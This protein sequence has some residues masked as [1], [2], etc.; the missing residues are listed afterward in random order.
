MFP[1]HQPARS[2]SRSSPRRENTNGRGGASGN[3][4]G[5]VMVET[6]MQLFHAR[7]GSRPMAC[8]KGICCMKQESE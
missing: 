4:G 5:S 8:L 3:S 6:R 7:H 2:G 1:T